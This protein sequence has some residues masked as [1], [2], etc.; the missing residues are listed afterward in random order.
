ML[1]LSPLFSLNQDEAKHLLSRVGYFYTIQDIKKL[2]KLNYKQAAQWVLNKTLV[3]GND[4]SLGGGFLEFKKFRNSVLKGMG[5]KT[6]LDNE[7]KIINQY[8]KN[9]KLTSRQWPQEI[10]QKKKAIRQFFNQEQR[11]FRKDLAIA[12]LSKIKKDP[13]NLGHKMHLFWHNHFVSGMEKVN[14]LEYIFNQNQYLYQNSLGNFKSMTEYLLFDPAMV[15]YLDI[16]KSK[17]EK[18]NENFSRELLELF[19]MGQGNYSEKDIKELARALTGIHFNWGKGKVVFRP[20]QHDQG[21]KTLF[22]EKGNFNP[23]DVLNVIFKQD[24]VSYFIAQKI[25]KHFV[26]PKID[27]NMIKK[28][29]KSFRESSYDVSVLMKTLLSDKRFYDKKYHGVLVKSPIEYM[30]QLEKI[31]EYL[32]VKNDNFFTNKNI[33][34]KYKQ[35]GFVFFNP[36][37]VRGYQGYTKWINTATLAVRTRFIDQ[38]K[39]RN[40]M[41]LNSKWKYKQLCKSL[42]DN[43]ICSQKKI[44][45]QFYM[46]LKSAQFQLK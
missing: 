14:N 28:M 24:D 2:E 11:K 36:P 4:Y 7:V 26:S 13:L 16:H 3:G 35:L 6:N 25:W 27:K 21:E 34:G 42:F 29:A 12:L 44:R 20:N 17:K 30:L 18:P 10:K 33:I 19:T 31:Y 15:F 38:A 22:G 45:Q 41:K 37:N 8:I 9:K 40:M 23:R 39:K 1:W 43:S 5:K 46:S 32:D